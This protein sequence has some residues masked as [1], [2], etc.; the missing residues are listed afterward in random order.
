MDYNNTIIKIYN[1]SLFIF[2]DKRTDE[3]YEFNFRQ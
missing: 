2:I 3:I 1:F